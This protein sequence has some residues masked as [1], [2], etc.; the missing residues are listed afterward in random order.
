MEDR[1]I[2]LR[3]RPVGK[4]FLLEKQL[5]VFGHDIHQIEVICSRMNGTMKNQCIANGMIVCFEAVHHAV[6]AVM[7]GQAVPADQRIFRLL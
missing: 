5:Q 7:G 1:L 4:T 3:R 2:N 6:V